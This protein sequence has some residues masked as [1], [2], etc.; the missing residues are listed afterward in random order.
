[1]QS[2]FVSID[3]FLSTCPS[4]HKFIHPSI[5]FLLS[6]CRH[7]LGPFN[8]WEVVI[9]YYFYSLEYLCK[10]TSSHHLSNSLRSRSYS[11]CMTNTWVF[12][13]TPVPSAV[14]GVSSRCR[15]WP[16]NPVML[17]LQCEFVACH[18]FDVCQLL[19]LLCLPCWVFPY[20]YFC[21]NSV[22]VR[23]FTVSWYVDIFQI[24]LCL[25][26]NQPFLVVTNDA[27]ET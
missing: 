24:N 8:N 5:L 19:Q 12:S 18:T 3:L 7:P 23:E 4:V 11:T 17:W 9:L 10:E 14:H 20:G 6:P 15:R 16:V 22:V 21:H 1:M 26:R 13:F 2:T 25:R 27:K